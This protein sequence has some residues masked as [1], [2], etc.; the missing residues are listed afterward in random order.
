MHVEIAPVNGVDCIFQT[1]KV[2]GVRV[3]VAYLCW[4]DPQRGP[5]ELRFQEE[6]GEPVMDFMTRVIKH[7]KEFMP[8]LSD[9]LPVN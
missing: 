2:D 6:P 4:E 7:M 9:D 5:T 8:L 3:R 1:E